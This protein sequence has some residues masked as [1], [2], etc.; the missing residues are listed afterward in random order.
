MN[1]ATT[2]KASASKGHRV[3]RVVPSS[4]EP[5][6]WLWRYCESDGELIEKSK[7][8]KLAPCLAS[9]KGLAY[10]ESDSEWVD[11]YKENSIIGSYGPKVTVPVPA[12]KAETVPENMYNMKPRKATSPDM[13]CDIEGCDLEYMRGGSGVWRDAKG[14]R[15][16]YHLKHCDQH[17]AE[18]VRG[19]AN[20]LRFMPKSKR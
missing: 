18:Y 4:S 19:S 5:G 12:A 3:V 10:R 15:H 2:M 7:S 16:T 11:I 1:T 20:Y 14:N 6:S 13:K 8:M 9:A 17:Y